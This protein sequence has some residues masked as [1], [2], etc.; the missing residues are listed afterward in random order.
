MSVSIQIP[1]NLRAFTAQQ[2]RV[3]VTGAT[4]AAALDELCQQHPQLR[5]KLLS[6]A[7]EL[8]SFVNVFVEGRAIRELNGLAT[9]LSD[10]DSLLIVPALAGG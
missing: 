3:V 7:G 5:D 1:A 2:S 8:H 9:P 6:A 10:G 4:V